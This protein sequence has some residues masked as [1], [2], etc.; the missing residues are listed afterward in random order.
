VE[1]D[2]AQCKTVEEE[3]CDEVKE[4][5]T[6]ELKCDKW[7]R[8][9]CT[10]EKKKVKKYTPN[11]SCEKVP[12]KMCAPRGCGIKQVIQNTSSNAPTCVRIPGGRPVPRQTEDGG[13]GQPCGGVRHGAHPDLQVGHSPLPPPARHITKLVPRLVATQECV[14]VP[15]EICA[16]SKVN[17]RKVKRPAIQKWCYKLNSTDETTKSPTPDPAECQSDVDCTAGYTCVQEEGKCRARPGK[18]SARY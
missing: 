2:V 14:D 6:T 17:P 1:D 9:V 5:F 4:G 13:G 11:T 12:K 7:P 18:V 3:K 8:E 15:K 16:R 10:L